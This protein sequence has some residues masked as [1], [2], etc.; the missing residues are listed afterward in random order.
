VDEDLLTVR[1]TRRFRAVALLVAAV[2][3]GAAGCRAGVVA[4][5]AGGS[6]VVLRFATI[7]NANP[8]GHTVAPQA[9]IDAVERLSGGRLHVDLQQ[10]FESG[11]AGAESDIV[12]RLRAGT[13]DGGWPVTRAFARAGISGLEPIEAPM[14]LTNVAA[15][16]ALATGDGGRVLLATLHGT[17]VVGLGLTVG[18]LR[19]PWSTTRP[20]VAPG[21]WRS[22]AFRSYNSP[23]ADSTIRA[24]GGRPTEA[25]FPFPAL[26]RS[27]RLQGVELDIAQYDHNH[28][29]DLLPWVVANEVLWPRMLVL[30]LSQKRW[31]TL[32]KRQRGW[33]TEAAQTAVS[34][35]A[36]AR[37]DE[38]PL[39][40]GLCTFGVRFVDATP[41]EV[42]AMRRAVQPVIAAL[43]ADPETAPGLAAV[44][45]AVQTHPGVDGVHVPSRCRTR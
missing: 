28:Y 4:D 18:P 33:L 23:V 43:A 25:S 17:G 10:S 6:V 24:L 16:R 40:A 13:L 2:A 44:Q 9:F 19:R 31:S 27:G 21:A 8:N 15:E 14:T 41:A 30:S 11:A 39:A 7:D 5:K 22:I 26:V 45:A 36:A 34:A 20:L 3:L 37:Y 35:S 29:A 42:T 1:A 32:T 12:K 38:A